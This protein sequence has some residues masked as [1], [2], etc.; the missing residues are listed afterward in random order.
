MSETVSVKMSSVREVLLTDGWHLTKPGT[1]A[2]GEIV[3]VNDKE[4]PE[5]HIARPQAIQWTDRDSGAQFTCPLSAVRA[6]KA[7]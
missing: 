5:G 7:H 3:F 1:F 4:T 6:I 2:V